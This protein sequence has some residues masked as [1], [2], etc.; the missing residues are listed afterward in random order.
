MEMQEQLYRETKLMEPILRMHKLIAG[1]DDLKADTL[2]AVVV[3]YITDHYQGQVLTA[4]DVQK[5]IRAVL[6]REKDG[7]YFAM[8]LRNELQVKLIGWLML[9]A[10]DLPVTL[11]QLG[12]LSA[13]FDAKL[14]EQIC[15]SLTSEQVLAMAYTLVEDLEPELGVRMKLNEAYY[16]AELDILL[17]PSH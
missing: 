11:E 10:A 13:D 1:E 15:L 2:L 12:D 5:I 17:Q 9:L 16:L 3:Q 6:L 7:K 4:A 8:Y 14:A